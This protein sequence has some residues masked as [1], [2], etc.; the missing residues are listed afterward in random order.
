MRWLLVQYR[1]TL[2]EVLHQHVRTQLPA[3]AQAAS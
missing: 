2:S 1:H 3:F